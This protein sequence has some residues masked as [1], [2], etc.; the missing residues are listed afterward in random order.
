MI[1]DDVV[2]IARLLLSGAI[3]H[4]YERPA[5]WAERNIIFAHEKDPIKGAIDLDFSPHLI[6]PLNAWELEPGQGLKEL[7]VVGPQQMGKT[8]TWLCGLLWSMV[9]RMSLSLIY[10]TSEPKAARVN[11]EKLE[12]VMRQIERFRKL[13]ALPN[14]K[15]KECYRLGEN[16]IYFGGV[17]SRISSHSARHVIADELDDWQDAEGTNALSDARTRC[18]AFLESLL[19]KVCTPRGTAKSS[20]I[21]REFLASSQGFRFLRCLGCGELTMRSCDIS[22]LK[23]ERTESGEVVP[24]TLRLVCPKCGH[25]HAESEKAEMNRRGGYRHNRP[26]RLKTHPGFQF[27]ALASNFPALSWQRIA[28]AQLKAGR[29]GIVQDQID[30][31][32]TIRGLPFEP[33]KLDDTADAMLK[34]HAVPP[35][36]ESEILYRFLSVDTQDNCF[37]WVVRGLDAARNTY[38]LA[39]GK[40]ETAAELAEAWEAQYHCGP[41]TM[42]IIDEGGH[43]AAEVREFAET[44]PGLFTY[45]GNPRIGKNW[46]LSEEISGLILANPAHYHLQLLYLLYVA[47]NRGKNFWFVPPELP[48]DYVAQLTSWKPAPTKDGRELENY[49]CPDA[50]DHYYDCEKMLLVLLD[51]FFEKVLPLLFAQQMKPQIVRRP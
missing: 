38:L 5:E 42:G 46:K 13:L 18:R 44:R 9:F 49:V 30:F 33:R 16:L 31:D 11:E 45:K 27:G 28:E 35:P 50:N 23:F 8:L 32:N 17:G 26:E 15:T 3:P 41:L 48:A 2:P 29:S 37:F 4:N 47:M 22:N 19:V 24:G 12:P 34:R 1:A 43:R 14:A 20:P 10:Y 25:A 36:P 6:D 39:S 51:F 21:W 7:T 40:A